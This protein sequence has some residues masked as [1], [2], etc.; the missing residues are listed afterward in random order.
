[1]QQRSFYIDLM[2]GLLTLGMVFAHVIQLL[3]DGQSIILEA[4]SIMTNLVSF[5][6]F[7]F[8]FGFAAW[9]AY[10]SK[11][12]IPK[13]S[14]AKTSFKCYLAFLI[15]GFAFRVLYNAKEPSLNLALNIALLR[16]IPGYSEF[17]LTFAMVVLVAAICKTIIRLASNN[18]N[19]LFLACSICIACT[20]LP[21]DHIH[22]PIVGQFIGG[23]NFAFF[24]VVQY[25]PL[26]LFGVFVA[27]QNQSTISISVSVVSLVLVG[28]FIYLN[29]LNVHISRFPPS[30]IW[31]ICSAGMVYIYLITAKLIMIKGARVFCSYLNVVGQNVLFYLIISNLVLF[32][33][34]SFIGNSKLNA[35]QVISFYCFLMM[36]IF[37]LQYILVD[38]KRANQS[39]NQKD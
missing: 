29:V 18:I 33:A 30:G 11:Q 3:G 16:D 28:I 21:S 32:V 31:V 6:G 34:Q 22:D 39:I 23:Q 9:V 27:R 25:F 36:F 19:N 7:I 13:A 38:L 15:S 37:F 24:P 14:V 2:K 17:L 10:L 1:M 4:F 5:S 12:N 26:F 20:F 35:G 8:C